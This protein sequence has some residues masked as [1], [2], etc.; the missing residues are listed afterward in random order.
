MGPQLLSTLSSPTNNNT[1]T[2]RIQSHQN[3]I[4]LV[5]NFHPGNTTF[6][7]LFLNSPAQLHILKK[8]LSIMLLII[9]LRLPATNDTDSKTIRVNFMSHFALPPRR[10]KH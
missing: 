8:E 9:P 6:S 3:F 5:V 10:Q 1:R 7:A 4:T 2:R